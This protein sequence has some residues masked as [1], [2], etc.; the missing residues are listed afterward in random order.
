MGGP[1][2]R[3]RPSNGLGVPGGSPFC[4]RIQMRAQKRSRV[5]KHLKLYDVGARWERRVPL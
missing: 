3:R 4:K 2:P 5:F 1:P